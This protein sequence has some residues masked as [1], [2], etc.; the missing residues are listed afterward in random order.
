MV[1]AFL[2]GK[3]E[4]AAL[5]RSIDWAQTPLGPIG[6]WPMSLK[7][8][9]GTLLRSRHPMF[10][11]WGAELIQFYND[12]Y[13]PSF[14]R[15]KHPAAMGQPGRQCWQEIWP[16]IGPQ[17][18]AVMTRGEATWNEDQL[19]PIYRNGGLQE[20]Y[21]TYGYSP[22]LDDSGAIGG[23]LV[24]CTETTA[25]VLSE[26]R[27]KTLQ[28]LTERCADATT[29][30][31]VVDAALEISASP[32]IIF[33]L[34][35]ASDDESWRFARCK[36]LPAPAFA[37]LTPWLSGALSDTSKPMF[38]P[39]EKT[40]AAKLPG[41]SWPESVS[42]IFVAPVEGST[43]R[44]TA[45]IVFG[46]SPRLTFDDHYRDFLLQVS[47]QVGA[48]ESR[49]EAARAKE[50][51]QREHERL[52]NEL[53]N[54]SRAKDEFLAM[55]GHELRNPLAPIVTALELMKLRG[56]G[57]TTKERA[58]I[59]RQV[60]H[61]V[62]LVDDLLDVAKITRGKVELRKENVEIAEVLTKAVEMA[63]FVLEQRSQQLSIKIAAGLR[64]HGDAVRLAQ[65]V[66]NLLTNAAR[67]TDPGG[68]ITLSA[69][70]EENDIVIRV[71]DNGRGISP[72]LL[73]H[74][75]DLFFQGSHTRD[76]A[77]GGLGI[78]LT[79][80]RSLVQLHGGSVEA[81]SAGVGKGS[82]LVVRLPTRDAGEMVD[83]RRSDRHTAQVMTQKPKRVLIV[84][85]N[86][87]A[88]ELLSETLR[89]VGHS[90]TMAR[91]PVEALALVDR[92]R[93][94]IAVL[95]IGL[96]VMDGYELAMK[97]KEHAAVKDCRFIALTG[98]G[99]DHDKVRSVAAGFAA[100]LVKP[101]DVNKLL[102][103]LE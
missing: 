51:D 36:G 16:I 5:I 89:A 6:Q 55:L 11:W 1:E 72:E 58:I 8:T 90:V 80:V 37:A 64:W 88:A 52:L 73:P 41:G 92:C 60:A 103:L 38:L 71:K 53:Q 98:Y 18:D 101:V 50:K 95:D 46:L 12:A 82:E 100:H 65:V 87:D 56:S 63:S 28:F 99:Q 15:G 85:D 33:S 3:S 40:V 31:Q 30:E 42:R 10:L 86:R 44:S 26:R 48:N 27:Q 9:V 69:E 67:Y 59:E 2:A 49:V 68:A 22:V 47:Q 76:R 84:D 61:L 70:V 7:T 45:A 83:R 81:L 96:P 66:S 57:E 23:T 19:V 24:V 97:L 39:I 54:A 29:A 102:A 79:L 4:S 74:V 14:G 25:R 94:E 32:D 35:M 91:D 93:P 75:F 34:Q 17:I 21:W 20:V 62:R 77:E 78:G 13:V 43:P